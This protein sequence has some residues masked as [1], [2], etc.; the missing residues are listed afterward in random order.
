MGHVCFHQID[1]GRPR[2]AAGRGDAAMNGPNARS[3]YCPFLGNLF[4]LVVLACVCGQ[5]LYDHRITTVV[6]L[7][8]QWFL[9]GSLWYLSRPVGRTPGGAA[10][11]ASLA[12]LIP[13]LSCLAL[14]VAWWGWKTNTMAICGAIPISDSASYYISAQG[15][16][17]EGFLDPSGQ[18][19]PVNVLLTSLWLFLSE[20]HVKTMLLIQA[21]AFS[22][23]AFLASAAVAALH[24]FRAGLVM[25]A[26]LL[27]FA[28]PYLP[29]TMSETNGIIFGTLSFIGF[30]FG[31]YRRSFFAFCLGALFLAVALAI[32]PS[33][34]FVLPC[35]VVAGCMIFATRPI[36]RLMVA[37]IL[38]GVMLVPI[39]SSVLLNK[40]L[41]RGDG[42]FNSNLSYSIYGLVSGGKG[43][44]QYEKDHPK[45]LDGLP[46]GERAHII[47][48]ASWRHVKEH[49]ADLVR[50]LAESQVVGPLQTFAQI[51]RLAWLGAAGDP[52]RI[53]PA[54]VIVAVCLLFAGVLVCQWA[55]K[56]Q[57][58]NV[59]GNVRLFFAWYLAGYLVSIPFFF[60]DGGLRLHA[61][62]LPV[63]S[64]LLVW[65]LLPAWA[66]G[67]DS[68]T[69]G[70]ADR[71]LWGASTYGFALIGLVAWIVLAQPRS[72]QFG[73]LAA[74]PSAP[75]GTIE[76]RFQSGWPSCDLR[77][78]AHSPA[79][80]KPRWFSG[81]IPDDGYRS[82]GLREIAGRGHLY[83]G[84]DE[85][86]RIWKIVRADDL[87]GPLNLIEVDHT[88]RSD[89][90]Y[91]D[92]Y[93]AK[94]TQ[95]INP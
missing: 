10:T 17:R 22:V 7:F 77:K 79:D 23:A 19:R 73:L 20:D 50:G 68:L 66:A 8:P 31:L 43:W 58:L 33:A 46:E 29:T 94:S 81:L 15:F 40:T 85:G 86:A 51:A 5:V 60:R 9:L 91:R 67:D 84:F 80:P 65:I 95:A 37:A 26:L 21:M 70:R 27:V 18:R 42:G 78:F 56:K 13:A 52:L 82:A 62:I 55:G 38:L 49:P 89:G 61:A 53:I 30:F 16:L 36:K 25:A 1:Q 64:Y 75:D 63:V 35:I 2:G 11:G 24:G 71:L 72:A 57:P 54:S 48:Q 34:M 87:A 93:S 47:L 39:G 28:E 32:R 74:P 59:R 69:R 41:S 3:R 45:T 92:F 6:A 44:E 83:F 4:L 88:E 76:F 12:V 90:R 14:L